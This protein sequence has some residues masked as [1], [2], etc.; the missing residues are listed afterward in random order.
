MTAVNID[1]FMREDCPQ[2]KRNHFVADHTVFV[3][4]ILK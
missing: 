4:H 1:G 3:E 2:I